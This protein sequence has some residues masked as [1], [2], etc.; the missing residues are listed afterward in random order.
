ML[1]P[2]GS[3]DPLGA[4]IHAGGRGACPFFCARGDTMRGLPFQIEIPISFFEKGD[5]E[6]GK[7]RR[8]GGVVTTASED[9]HGEELDQSGIEWGDWLKNGWYN[10]NHTKETDGIVGYP[11][12]VKRYRKGQRLPNGKT[13]PADCHWAEG[14][15]LPTDRADRLWELGK[16]LQG[17]GRSLGYSV[18]GVIKARTGPRTILKKGADGRP[19]YVGKRVAKAL[20]RNVAIT[21][22]PVN[23][24]AGMELLQRSLTA[25]EL[26]DPD[27]LEARLNVL[28]KAM[29]MGQPPP[30]NAAPTGPVTGEGAGQVI[31][32]QSL[33]WDDPKK[34]RKKKTRLKTDGTIS[35][36][37]TDAEA[38]A[39]VRSRC[40][41]LDDAAVERF[42]A[43][44]KT[45]K[46]TG[47]L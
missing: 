2:L 9:R 32:P 45:L 17:T 12:Y 24:E 18:E 27:D 22:C 36:S 6:P 21:N 16:A 47:R 15:M 4:S 30:G 20:V 44:T 8:I 46:R 29:S 28:E 40:P 43:T 14:Y 31:T 25:V 5:A 39:W 42:L 26:A 38:R 11:E 13:A 19:V 34:K 33:E 23:T 41:A 10:D 7:R 37:L 3:L 35:K 1:G